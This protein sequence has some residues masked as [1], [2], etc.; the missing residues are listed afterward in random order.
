QSVAAG[1]PVPPDGLIGRSRGMLAVYKQIARALASEAPVL[2]TGETGTGKELVAQAIHRN[3]RRA[4][5]AFVAFNCGAL[6]EGILESE[7]FGHVRGSFTGAVADKKGLFEQA[8]GGTLFLDEI[9]ETSAAVQ[10]KLLRA[11]EAGEV[12]PVGGS[13]AVSVDVRVIAATNRDLD[14][15]VAEGIFRRDLFFRLNVFPIPVPPLRERRDDVPLL[16][17]HFL[18]LVGERS[19]KAAGLTPAAMAALQEHRWPGNVRELENAVERLVLEG[20]GGTIDAADLPP[21]MRARTTPL[22]ERLF[23]DLPS[24]EELEKR[25]LAHVL[26]AMKGNRSRAA[27]VLGIDRRTLYRMAERFGLELPDEK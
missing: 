21:A 16:V 20:P 26:T 24:L 18:R 17:N 6:A 2:I 4:A 25:Y 14:R 7:L 15:A 12:R 1:E 22:P 11:L 10:V 23:E 5:R 27:E 9:G 3:G 19:G 13:R 8:H